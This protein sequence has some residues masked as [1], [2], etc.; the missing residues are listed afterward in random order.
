MPHRAWSGYAM[1][2]QYFF[3]LMQSRFDFLWIRLV[4]GNRGAK[5]VQA[6]PIERVKIDAI[7]AITEPDRL[8]ELDLAVLNG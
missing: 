8:Q 4:V 6:E 3:L 1:S 7:D 2:F 5:L